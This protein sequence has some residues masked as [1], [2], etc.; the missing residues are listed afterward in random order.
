MFEQKCALSAEDG[1]PR[2]L[3]TQSVRKASLSLFSD[4]LLREQVTSPHS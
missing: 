3:S 2:R 1:F 4:S